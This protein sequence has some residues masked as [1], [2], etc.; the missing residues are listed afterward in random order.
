MGVTVTSGARLAFSH[1]PPLSTFYRAA[2]SILSSMRKPN[3]PVLMKLLYSNCVPCLT[4][5]SEV[6]DYKSGAMNNLNVAL[7]DARGGYTH[8]L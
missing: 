2:N 1:K 6:V 7:N 8:F 3:E 5:A 4:Y